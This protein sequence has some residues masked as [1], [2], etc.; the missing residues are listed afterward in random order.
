MMGGDGVWG[1]GMWGMGWGMFVSVILLVALGFAV[2]YWMMPRRAYTRRVEDD[3]L[4]VAERRLA[5]GEITPA[6]FDE[7]RKKLGG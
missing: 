5:R 6:E 1:W 7:I 4:A 3:P 2:Y